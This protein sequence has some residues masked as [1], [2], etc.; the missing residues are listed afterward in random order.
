[1][2]GLLEPFLGYPTILC[3]SAVRLGRNIDGRVKITHLQDGFVKDF[4]KIHSVGDLVTAR[5]LEYVP[6]L[7]H[8]TVEHTSLF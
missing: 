5:V 8:P 1:M 2:P 3:C 4:K 7:A 6:L